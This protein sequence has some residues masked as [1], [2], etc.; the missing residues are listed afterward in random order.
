MLF[1]IVDNAQPLKFYGA[2]EAQFEPRVTKKIHLGV[3]KSVGI[4]AVI[5]TSPLIPEV[6]V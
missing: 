2:Y 1:S 5:W 3:F 4:V 6:H